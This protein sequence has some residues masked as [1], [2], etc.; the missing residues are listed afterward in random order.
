MI[1][2]RKF[3]I[4][5]AGPTGIGAA[6]RLQELQQNSFILIDRNKAFGGLSRSI[7]DKS[8]FT[9]DL[10][11]HV[12]F[13]HYEK[14]DNYM[15]KAFPQNDWLSHNRSSWI[16]LLKK[17]VPYPFQ[18][19]LHRL[20]PQA[21]WACCKGLLEL[22]KGEKKP[23]HNFGEWIDNTFG[24]GI[25]QLFMR[26]YNNKVWAY[27]PETMN[28]KWIGERVAVPKIE[29]VLES[30]CLEKDNNGWG[31]NRQFR[32]PKYGGTGAI[33]KALGKMIPK[34][35][36]KMGSELSHVDANNKV[37]HLDDGNKV[38]YDHLISSIPLDQLAVILGHN[39]LINKT[40]NLKFSSTHVIG[41]GMDGQPTKTLKDKCWIY[42]PEN[43]F[44][45]YRLTVFSNYSPYNTP[46]PEKNWSLMTEVSAN[47]KKPV[48]V[49]KIIEDTTA[50]L[51]HHGMIATKNR[52]VTIWH[53]K[54]KYAYPTPSIERDSIIMEVMEYLQKNGIYS[55]GRFGYWKYEVGNQ[56]HSFM[57]GMEIVDRI[58]LSRKELTINEPE[59]INSRYNPFPY[60][61]WD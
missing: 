53:K 8:G 45:F 61:E 10:G 1:E 60:K 27:P 37:I 24:V 34:E 51:K 5:G 4:I 23:V 40:R 38:Q 43:E 7:E 6:L 28:Y 14:F 12:L 50:S 46:N 39:T 16:Y 48:T 36:V 33:W 18:F 31:P 35:H 2:Y 11:G 56:D 19:N 26:P 22:H 21:R 3:A 20:P 59:K 30:I 49:K 25:A 29:T 42:F 58:L 41:I 47:R 32:F 9:W 54:L 52:I 17:F 13:S 15:A 57:Q 55:R 44:P